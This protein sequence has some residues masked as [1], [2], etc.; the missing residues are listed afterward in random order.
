MHYADPRYLSVL[1]FLMITVAL[2]YLWAMKRR[3]KLM[4][5][6]AEKTLIGSIAPTISIERK[7]VKMAI[8]AAAVSLLVFA[9][10]RPQWGFFALIGFMVLT[11]AGMMV[12][13]RTRRWF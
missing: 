4:D 11:V 3:K 2:F 1:I 12:Y 5:R 7:V 10:A 8:L 9:L 13:F 6:F